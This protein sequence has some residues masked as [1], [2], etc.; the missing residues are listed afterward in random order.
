M[1]GNGLVAQVV[2]DTRLPQLAHPFDYQ[3]PDNLRDKAQFG[4]RVQVPLRGG[5]GGKYGWIV[6]FSEASSFPGK[7]SLINSVVGDVPVLDPAVWQLANTLADRAAGSVCDILRVA[8]PGRH[9]RA[10]KTF[11]AKRQEF[12]QA[13]TQARNALD[14]QVDDNSLHFSPGGVYAHTASHGLTR[15]QNGVWVGNWAAQLAQTAVSILLKKQSVIICVPDWR[16]IEQAAQALGDVLGA[17]QQHLLVRLDAKQAA[18]GRFGQFLRTTLEI[19]QIILGNR[20]AIYAP[21]Y[22]LGAIIIWDEAD[23]LYAEP[24]APYVHVRDAALARAQQQKTTLLF[25]GHARSTDVQRLIEIGYVQP[26][27][28]APVRTKITHADMQIQPDMYGGRI[29]EA[30]YRL[31]RTAYQSGPVLVQVA[32]PGY[33]HSCYC[34]SCGEKAFCVRCHGPL[35]AVQ[36]ADRL[37]CLWCLEQAQAWRCRECGGK[38]SLLRSAGS[39]RTAEQLAQHFKNFR[40]IIAD[41]QNIVSSIDSRPAIVVATPG[42]EPL[43]A[44]GYSAVVILDAERVLAIPTLRAA[45]DALRWWENAA[46]KAATG[47]VCML[48]TGSGPAVQAFIQ[49]TTAA[50]LLFELHERQLLRFPPMVR[51]AALTGEKQTVENAIAKVAAIADVDYLEPVPVGAGLWRA[52]VR[53]SYRSAGE[54]A[55]TLRAQIMAEAVGRSKPTK[56]R[57]RQKIQS[58]LRVK[59]DDRSIFDEPGSVSSKAGRAQLEGEPTV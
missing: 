1:V 29:P 34:A 31:I 46:A 27:A 58:G 28:F 22:N 43:P 49:G 13:A 9:A 2:L 19:P 38:Q 8:V 3:V 36:A 37:A 53:M 10:E 30:V 12:M 41:G 7:L 25:A 56:A 54:V 15:L 40:L 17:G 47:A 20:S 4:S 50:Y 57:P 11:L 32:K 51:V 24:L 5:G 39:L 59:F 21:A 23:P 26:T 52:V 48:A 18:S 42:A 6:G 55:K 14:T 35:G 33:A 16:D 44:G 45:E